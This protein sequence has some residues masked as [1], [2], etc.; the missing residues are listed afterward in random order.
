MKGTTKKSSKQHADGSDADQE[1]PMLRV[2]YGRAKPPMTSDK[3][4]LASRATRR[5]INMVQM[6]PQHLYRHILVCRSSNKAPL[7]A[8][9]RFQ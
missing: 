3:L 1:R 7:A 5:R 4:T 6:Y 9:A 8:L 2:H